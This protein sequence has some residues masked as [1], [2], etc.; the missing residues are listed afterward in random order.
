MIGEVKE[1]KYLGYVLKQNDGPEAQGI[2]R[3]AAMAMG[4]VW[5]IGKRRYGSDWERRL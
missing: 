3:K 1:F 4:Q 5:G 2:E